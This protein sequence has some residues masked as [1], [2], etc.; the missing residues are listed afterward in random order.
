MRGHERAENRRTLAGH[1]LAEKF[2]LSV[3]LLA[4]RTDD[5]FA[6]AKALKANGFAPL[7]ISPNYCDDIE[8]ASPLKNAISG[9]GACQKPVS[10]ITRHMWQ[11][12]ML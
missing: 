5:I 8:R 10:I 3:Q 1:F 9:C 4:F 11:K 2:G 7:Q 6:A 12:Q